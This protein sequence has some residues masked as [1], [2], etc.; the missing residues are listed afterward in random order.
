MVEEERVVIKPGV[1]KDFLQS[2][3]AVGDGECFMFSDL[4][5]SFKKI[6]QLNKACD[7]LTARPATR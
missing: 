6:E 5:M 2:F 1:C 3:K 4:N 7:S